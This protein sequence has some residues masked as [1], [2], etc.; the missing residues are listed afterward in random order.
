MI[1]PNN[2]SIILD[3]YNQDVFCILVVEMPNPIKSP[4]V[5]EILLIHWQK[6][7]IGFHF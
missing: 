4:G 5:S 6:A 1:R 7:V 3:T 2:V